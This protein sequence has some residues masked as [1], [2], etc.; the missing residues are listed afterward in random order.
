M[1]YLKTAGL[2][3]TSMLVMSMAVASSASAV[4]WEGC[5]KGGTSA[6]K[7]ETSNCQKTES[8]GE[9]GWEEFKTT[10]R[11]ISVGF[12]IS[13]K[14]DNTLLGSSA[15]VCTKGGRDSGSVGP[16]G[17]DR[18]E[19][20]FVEKASENC[21]R[22]EG[23][24]KAGEIEAVE[25]ANLPWQTEVFETEKKFLTKIAGTKSG[26]EP[27]WIVKCN[28]LG[29]KITDEC[30]TAAGKEESVELTNKETKNGTKIELLVLATFE[31]KQ[32]A[33][34]TQGLESET[35]SILGQ[36]AILLAKETGNEPSGNG[37]RI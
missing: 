6:S 28:T 34:C 31:R 23:G 15:V 18:I 7:Y 35:G 22:L 3:L 10:D 33:N 1:K 14:D 11:V 5:L 9:W 37:L 30:L 8:G 32:K 12:T 25:G 20:A 29:G 2:C 13:L 36:S 21:T 17:F 27:G 24:C 19:L 16:K 4:V 26:K